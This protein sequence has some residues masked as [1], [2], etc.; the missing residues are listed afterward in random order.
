MKRGCKTFWMLMMAVIMI[1]SCSKD[2]E[3]ETTNC[4]DC[5]ISSWLGTFMG[6]A[7]VYNSVSN[8]TLT[9]RS[10]TVRFEQAGEDYLTVYVA[11]PNLFNENMSGSF[12]LPYSV[13]FA[14]TLKSFS[15]TLKKR[16]D[17]LLLSGNAKNY[18]GKG[19]D[20]EIDKVVTFEDLTRSEGTN[21]LAVYRCCFDWNSDNRYERGKE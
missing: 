13:S 5:T 11:V 10:I 14:G 8:E 7:D 15:A 19:D 16:G 18:H 9:G 2:K 17:Q 1:A 20:P 6:T 21:D 12:Y 3:E 4:Y